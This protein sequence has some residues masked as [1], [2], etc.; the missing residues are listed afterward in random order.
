M[1][2]DPSEP[3]V[4]V[5]SGR[6]VIAITHP[7]TNR[8][9]GDGGSRHDPFGMKGSYFSARR[10]AVE[11]EDDGMRMR[12]SGW[13]R[14]L[15]AYTGALERAG[16]LIEAVREPVSVR[17]DGATRPVPFHLWIRALRPSW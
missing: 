1:P 3:D 5:S 17:R 7:V 8:E 4:S 14:P 13:D 16:L 2:P 11:E 9:P 6:F 15:S 12:F 10:V